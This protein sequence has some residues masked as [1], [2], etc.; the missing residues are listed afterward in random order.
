MAGGP[1]RQDTWAVTVFVENL[2]VPGRPMQNLGIW[3]K[4]SGGEVDSEEYKYS[5]GAMAGTISLGG[6][7]NVGNVTVSRL[8]RLMRDHTSEHQ[9]LITGV[10][11][12]R[13]TV[14]QQPLDV[15]GNVFG[16]PLVLRGT[17]KRVTPPEVDSESSDAAMVELEITPEGEPVVG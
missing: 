12:A 1:T 7:K 11:K 4:K 8:Y 14:S 6:R 3:D 10:G 13:A 17:L 9:M 2:L 15:D 5:P 16:P